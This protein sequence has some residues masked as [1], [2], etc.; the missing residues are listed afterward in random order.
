MIK[1]TLGMHAMLPFP[2]I[3]APQLPSANATLENKI[4]KAQTLLNHVLPR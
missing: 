4:H 1:D 3:V 2:T